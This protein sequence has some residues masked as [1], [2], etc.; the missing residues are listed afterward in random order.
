[1]SKKFSPKAISAALG[2]T[3]VA[4]L[5][6][7]PAVQ[8]GENP[9]SVTELSTGYMLAENTAEARCGEAT[10]GAPKAKKVS[11]ANCGAT[12]APTES[13]C[14]AAPKAAAE[15]SCGAKAPAE[16]KCGADN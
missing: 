5:A 8:A 6:V 3:L 12:K 14:G 9:F 13:T 7:T 16:A 1:M 11:E 15:A 10:C 4:G 2:G